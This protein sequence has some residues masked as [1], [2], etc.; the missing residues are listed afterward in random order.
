MDF[1]MVNKL[2]F[3]FIYNILMRLS[4]CLNLNKSKF[5]KKRF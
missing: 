5:Y 2:K 1:V 4:N 3:G